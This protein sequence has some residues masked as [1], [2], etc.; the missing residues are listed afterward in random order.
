[1]NTRNPIWRYAGWLVFAGVAGLSGLYIYLGPRPL[2]PKAQVEIF[3]G[4]L[5]KFGTITEQLGQGRLFVLD[6]DTVVGD[7]ENLELFRVK[8]RLEEP[9]T[10]WRMDS[11]SGRRSVG[12][13]TLQGPMSVVASAS[14]STPQLG[15]GTI[16]GEGPAL[17]WDRGVWRGLAPLDWQDLEGQG[18]GH[19]HLPAGWRRELDGRFFVDKGPVIWEASDLGV[20]RRMEADRL[21]LTL[22]LQEGHLDQV[23]ADLEG[24]RIWAGSADL[25]EKAIRWSAPFRFERVDGWLGHAESGFAPRPAKGEPL[26]QV[27]LRNFSATRSVPGG[28]EKLQAGGTRWSAAGL[29]LEGDVRWEQPRDGEVLVLR[30]PRFMLREAPGPDLPQSLPVGEAWAEGHPVLSWGAKSLTSPSM[31]AHRKTRTWRILAPV[32]GRAE[33]GTFSAGAGHGSPGR[34]EFEGPIKANLFNGGSLRGDKLR[35][36]SDTWTVTGN[37]ATW[38]RIRERLAGP[39]IIRKGNSVAFPDGVTGSLASSDGDFM[40]RADRANYEGNEVQL[41]GNVECQGR[42]WRLQADTISVRLGAGNMVKRVIAKGSVTLRGRMGE[43][44]GESL[45]LDLDSTP[46]RARW[47]GRVRGL[48]EVKP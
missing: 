1:L 32:L 35:W 47:Q 40:V 19:W 15:K 26:E 43:G 38:S 34:W 42:G 39:R 5:G 37:P 48:A 18:K 30:A 22:G 3:R 10:L 44:W 20:L 28:T 46:S 7:Q 2:L 12:V 25:D 9:G 17:Q 36:E 11:P 45:E 16:P 31:Q 6:Y 24:G 27:E 13:W 14:A 29:R 41:A 23:L 33:Q 21:W 4:S 8:A